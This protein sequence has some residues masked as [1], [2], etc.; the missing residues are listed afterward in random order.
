MGNLFILFKK[1]SS[2]FLLLSVILLIIASFYTLKPSTYSLL[3]SPITEFSTERALQHLKII[4][5][6]P[7]HLG[8]KA[9]AEVRN[10]ILQELDA[11]GLETSTQDGYI[12]EKNENKLTNILAK[13]KGNESGKALMLMSHY[14]SRGPHSFGASDAGSGVVTILEGIRAFLKSG[15]KPK[16]DIIILISDGEE[17]GLLGAKLFV[18]EHPWAKE[19]GLALNFEARGSGGPS[20]MLMETNSGNKELIKH[21]RKANPKYP[22]ANSLSYSI[23]KMLPNDTDLTVLRE[24]Q[25]IPGFNFAFI[26]DH[27][28]YHT[29]LDNYE[30]LDRTT[31]EHQGTYLMPLLTY[32]S[33]IDLS[34]LEAKEDYVFFN[35]PL[36]KV[37]Y[38]PFSWILP[39]LIIATL[40]FITLL[41]YGNKK[42]QLSFSKT[43]Y[44]FLPFS[45]TLILCGL[46]G[47][48][49]W[50]LINI[51][52]P[53]YKLIPNRFPYNGHYYMAAF[54]LLS[55]ALCSW[56]YGFF[57]NTRTAELLI[58]PLFLWLIIG[59]ATAFYLQGASYFLLF[60][61][62][63]LLALYLLFSNKNPN[64]FLLLLCCAPALLIMS[65]M[66]KMLT[67]GLGMKMLFATGV[68]IAL[69]YG[70]CLPVFGTIKNQKEIGF[71]L[72]LISLVFII[73]A[74]FSL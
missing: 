19:V 49:G 61:L 62:F 59:A 20:H 21:F 17:L 69:I 35:M 31:L 32:F 66:I 58:A 14:D 23:Y 57:S 9:H 60:V 52:Y 43:L 38:Y 5:Q 46:V 37:V 71:L 7:H 10:Y 68:L 29:A 42:G 3:E 39:M 2:L 6:K 8:T 55:I 15:E 36:I 27:F 16:N 51:I 1:Y 67:V 28:D 25:N 24:E 64:K 12:L 65:P 56:V 30:R 48:Y 50:S 74:H 33:H 22:V 63:G 45:I 47:Y 41:W 4:S 44:G 13:I 18:R 11:L 72:F 70:I 73:V 53:E 40:I 26:D 34:T 54:A